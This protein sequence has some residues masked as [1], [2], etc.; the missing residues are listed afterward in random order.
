MGKLRRKDSQIK[1]IYKGPTRS[2]REIWQERVFKVLLFKVYSMYYNL[3]LL[4]L[5]IFSGRIAYE[6][7][8]LIPKY[9]ILVYTF[10]RNSLNP[11]FVNYAFTFAIS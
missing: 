11:V 10:H 5:I 3:I 4:I 1:H 9:M 8:S 6:N 7:P 2:M